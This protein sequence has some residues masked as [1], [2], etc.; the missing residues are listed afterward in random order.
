VEF[1]IC[2]PRKPRRF[3]TCYEFTS[4]LITGCH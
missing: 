1:S 2:L 3:P 4:R